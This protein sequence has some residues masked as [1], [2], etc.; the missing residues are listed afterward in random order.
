MFT[1]YLFTGL[2]II[3]ATIAV[4]LSV[5]NKHWLSGCF[6]AFTFG[7]AASIVI[8]IWNEPYTTGYV[9][10]GMFFLYHG[11]MELKESLK[12]KTTTYKDAK[13]IP[14]GVLFIKNPDGIYSTIDERSIRS[15]LS[16]GK[17]VYENTGICGVTRYFCSD[18]CLN[19]QTT[20]AICNM[21][22]GPH[23][24]IGYN[25]HTFLGQIAEVAYRSLHCRG[26]KYPEWH[27]V[28]N[29]LPTQKDC[30]QRGEVLVEDVNGLFHIC[31]PT[32][33][34][35]YDDESMDWFNGD[36]YVRPAYWS[37]IVPADPSWNV[38]RFPNIPLEPKTRDRNKP[39]DF[40][41]LI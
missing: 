17:A 28:R 18:I 29:E 11:I 6:S 7:L 19:K 8:P 32:N 2:M 20:N 41:E 35:T 3:S 4:I 22:R 36:V 38:V 14:A 23:H 37:C 26:Q 33:S 24:T 39:V 9:M 31:D 27:D 30:T 16:Q 1:T 15:V 12:P 21:F 25:P 13:H 40:M 10:V 34:I 5:H